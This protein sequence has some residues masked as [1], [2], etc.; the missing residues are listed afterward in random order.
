MAEPGLVNGVDT[1]VFRA[2][3]DAVKENPNTG[4]TSWRVSTKWKGGLKTEATIRQFTLS[5]DEPEGVAGEDTTQSP[6]ETVLACYGACLSVGMALNSALR[7]IELQNVEIELEGLIDLPGFLGLAGVEDLQDMPG[8]HTVRAKM[9][10][11]SDASREEIQSVFDR[12]TQ[13]SPV[14]LTLS[15]PVKIENALV[16]N[17]E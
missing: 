16:F 2:T 15:Q 8:F 6:H 9:F 5:F 17:G 7:G 4:A 10:V 3:I 13:Y 11:E 1:E 14:G 12:A